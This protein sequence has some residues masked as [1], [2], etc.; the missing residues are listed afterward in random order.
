MNLY[1]MRQ[2][3]LAQGK[4]THRVSYAWIVIDSMRPVQALL[5]E[6]PGLT[7]LTGAGDTIREVADQ[8]QTDFG[9]PLNGNERIYL[10]DPIGN[11]MMSY[12]ADI[13]PSLMLKD[14]KRLLQVSQLG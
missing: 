1:N 10:I 12:S 11:L 9:H 7:V 13:D 2:V 14:L 3:R 4:N 5:A 8:F 6:H